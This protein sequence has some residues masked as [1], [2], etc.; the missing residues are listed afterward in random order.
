MNRLKNLS[1]PSVPTISD[2]KGLDLVNNDG[3]LLVHLPW[4]ALPA[5]VLTV[6]AGIR[7]M[8]R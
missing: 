1:F 3:E 7:P 2:G 8:E 5:I 4:F 6:N